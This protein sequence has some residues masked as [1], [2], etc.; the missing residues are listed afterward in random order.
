MRCTLPSWPSTSSLRRSTLKGRG[1][2]S[3]RVPDG[4][5][6]AAAPDE[7]LKNLGLLSGDQPD[8]LPVVLQKEVAV[9]QWDRRSGLSLSLINVA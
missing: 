7:F 1:P 8:A 2:G 9:C 3:P 5:G 4:D 6:D